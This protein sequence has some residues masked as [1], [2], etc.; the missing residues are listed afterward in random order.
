MDTA[1]SFSP[2]R[3]S[4]PSVMVMVWRRTFLMTFSTLPFDAWELTGVS[5][6]TVLPGLPCA[7]V[8]ARSSIAFS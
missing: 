8:C 4:R 5:L 2:M 3:S 6:I 7:I 1:N